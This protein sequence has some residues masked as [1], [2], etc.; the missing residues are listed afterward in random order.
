MKH[1]IT[2]IT[3]AIA[4]IAAF[5]AGE[6]QQHPALL[7]AGVI[8]GGLF[9]LA[10]LTRILGWSWRFLQKSITTKLF[11]L[12]LVIVCA[13]I[14][15]HGIVNPIVGYGAGVSIG[16]LLSF[17]LVRS[18]SKHAHN[19]MIFGEVFSFLTGY[20]VKNYI[21]RQTIVPKEDKE[22]DSNDRQNIILVLHQEFGF[23]KSE[24]KQAADYA[25]SQTPL[26]AELEEKIKT[27][28]QYT[29]KNFSKN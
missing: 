2:T 5:I 4:T 7:Y 18:V 21:A 23:T 20:Q 13:L 3:L 9:A 6:V 29:A 19:S 8:L 15:Y 10:V 12:G 11:A 26:N 16:I 22:A 28:L 1:I 14:A 17:S 27:A 25:V 24:A